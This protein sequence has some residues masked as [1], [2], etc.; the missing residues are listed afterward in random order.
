MGIENEKEVCKITKKRRIA[1]VSSMELILKMK[2]KMKMKENPQ[3]ID[4]WTQELSREDC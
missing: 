4:V 3:L 2:R 1:N